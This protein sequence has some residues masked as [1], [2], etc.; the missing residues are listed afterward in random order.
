METV[1]DA[2]VRF[3]FTAH[4]GRLVQEMYA[5]YAAGSVAFEGAPVRGRTSIVTTLDALLGTRA[6]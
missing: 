3:G 2:F 6:A 5:G 4:I 1:A